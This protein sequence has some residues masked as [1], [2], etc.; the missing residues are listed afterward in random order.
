[1]CTRS[2]HV[3]IYTNQT[4]LLVGLPRLKCEITTYSFLYTYCKW[5]SY[6]NVAWKDV[7]YSTEYH[8]PT[9]AL[10]IYNNI[11]I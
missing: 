6:C 5:K 7:I 3:A 1:M 10:T 8:I 9:N 2:V 4:I 11:L